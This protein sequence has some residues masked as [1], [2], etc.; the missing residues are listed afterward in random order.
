[1][2]NLH[3]PINKPEMS[4]EN[5]LQLLDQVRDLLAFPDIDDNDWILDETMKLLQITKGV[6]STL[7]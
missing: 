3:H 6:N 5:K 2:K 4:T 7:Q 1:M